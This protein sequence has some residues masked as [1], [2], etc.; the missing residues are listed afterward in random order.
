M[1]NW[2]SQAFS[3]FS[4]KSDPAYPVYAQ[5]LSLGTPAYTPRDYR[6]VA[7]ESYEKNVICYRA[8][9]LIAQSCAGIP[10]KL[11]RQKRA[12]REI[13]D[14]PLLALLEHPNQEQS[15]A[16]LLEQLISY[17]LLSGNAYLTCVRPSPRALP[18]ELWSLRPDRMRVIPGLKAITGYEYS[19]DTRSTHFDASEVMHLKMFA[20]T[21]DWYG[22]SPVIVCMDLIDQNNEGND[23]NIALLQN[24][25]RPS[26]ALVAAGSL[27]ADQYDR[28]RKMVRERYI[29]KRNAGL[30]LLLEGG[31]DWKPFSMS[32]M[33]LDWLESRRQNMRDIAIALGVPP[34]LLGDSANKTYCLPYDSMVM[35]IDGPV[36]IGQIRKGTLVY[37]LD[38]NQQMTVNPVLWMSHVGRRSLYRISVGHTFLR[39]TGTHPFLVKKDEQYLFVHAQDLAVGDLVVTAAVYPHL[40]DACTALSFPDRPGVPQYCDLYQITS[41]ELLPPEEVYDLEV[42][43]TH[44]FFANHFCVHNSNYGEARTSFYQETI[45]PMMDKLRDRLNGWLTVQYGGELYLDYDKEEI[46]A[47]QEDR[48]QL[49]TR[50]S[51]QWNSGILTLNETRKAVGLDELPGGDILQLKATGVYYIPTAHLEEIVQQKIENLVA[52]PTALP[53]ATSTP[54]MEPDTPDHATDQE[55]TGQQRQLTEAAMTIASYQHKQQA[56][57]A[58][59]AQEKTAL[60]AAI[61]A[62]SFPETILP[63]LRKTLVRPPSAWITLYQTLHTQD[64]A[65]IEGD[66]WEGEIMEFAQKQAESSFP[67]FARALC[68]EFSDAYWY[69]QTKGETPPQIIAR[70]ESVYEQWAKAQIPTIIHDVTLAVQQMQAYLEKCASGQ[71][72]KKRWLAADAQHAFLNGQECDLPEVFLDETG[73][74]M[75]FPGDGTKG[76]LCDI[77]YLPAE[78]PAKDHE[79]TLKQIDLL[80]SE[81]VRPA[82]RK[83]VIVEER[84]EITEEPAMIQADNTDPVV[85]PDLA[86][87]REHLNLPPEG[88]QPAEEPANEETTS[89]VPAEEKQEEKSQDEPET[90]GAGPTETKSLTHQYRSFMAR[91]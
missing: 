70:M 88:H 69:S 90:V 66:A 84:Q 74:A 14:H 20:S 40:L 9:S 45:L 61:K 52:P 82:R 91:F 67:F 43:G 55:R 26:G 63:R 57:R 60:F 68:D 71:L 5:L 18:Q 28:L 44:T 87:Q 1:P 75:R 34:E 37:S 54:S 13:Q 39:A 25:G 8:V 47:L 72:L 21:N 32:P 2:L 59:F 11:Y 38:G 73:R 46:E 19:V 35:T 50:V 10:W 27:G 51:A 36:P 33:E 83:T 3:F 62:A 85:T 7:R 23:W 31:L 42:E 79:Q 4:R 89:D 56:V 15:F 30:P 53:G 81:V 41:I 49:S 16:D 58:Y 64:A 76:C 48:D 17:W 24:A 77:E 86:E 65:S 78:Q 29:G 22:L 80:L 6:T 12:L